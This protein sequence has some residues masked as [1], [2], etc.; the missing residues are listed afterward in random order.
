MPVVSPDTCVPSG[1]P[2]FP[3]SIT[4]ALGE[5]GRFEDWK[6][7]QCSWCFLEEVTMVHRPLC[8]C[9]VSVSG[10]MASHFVA[11]PN[12]AQLTLRSPFPPWLHLSLEVLAMAPLKRCYSLEQSLE[13]TRAPFEVAS[14]NA[15][16]VHSHSHS[17]H[18]FLLSTT[19]FVVISS[20]IGVWLS[21]NWIEQTKQQQTQLSPRLWMQLWLGDR[22]VGKLRTRRENT[23]A[24]KEQCT[25]PVPGQSDSVYVK[26]FIWLLHSHLLHCWLLLLSSP[27][28][29]L[30]C[31]LLGSKLAGPPPF[32]LLLFLFCLLFAP[33]E[34]R[35]L[36]V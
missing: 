10:L 34:L 18:S 5:K 32:L 4:A 25:R 15:I 16:S 13:R 35:K 17:T 33:F 7:R 23:I 1:A 31:P 14:T 24:P 8:V 36:L 21:D 12:C 27:T 30:F 20:R 9:W 19:T 3:I 6:V 2:L 22:L 26:S 29:Q 11:V 28:L